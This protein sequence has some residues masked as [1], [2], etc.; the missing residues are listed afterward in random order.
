MARQWISK[1]YMI[2]MTGITKKADVILTLDKKTFYPLYKEFPDTK[3]ILAY[4]ELFKHSEQFVFEYDYANVDNFINNIPFKT[5][6]EI[7]EEN[8][9]A[10]QQSLFEPPS[11]MQ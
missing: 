11:E 7:A 10:T 9:P 5:L 3:C 6:N 1:D 2:A 8:T 4:P